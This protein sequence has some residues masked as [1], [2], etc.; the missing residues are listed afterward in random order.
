[1]AI[2]TNSICTT[3]KEI[4][5]QSGTGAIKIGTFASANTITIG[6]TTGA[7]AIVIN[8][9]SGGISMPSFT[10]T[11]ALVSNSSGLITDA[12]ASTSG[13][14]LTSNGAVTAPSFQ[15]ISASGAITTI[16]GN[17]GSVTP[18]TGAVTISGTGPIS[19]S[20]SS[21]T[22]TISTTAANTINATSGTA[23]ASSNAFTIVGAGTVSTSA[24][25]STIT[26]TG[27]GGGGGLSWNNVTGSTQA[28]AVNTGYVNNGSGTPTVFTLPSTAAVG[29][30][31]AVQGANSGLWQIAQN[32]GQTIAF[33]AITST[34]GTGGS[35]TAT[36]RYDTLYLICITANTGWAYNSGFGN[37]TIA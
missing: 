1:M 37:Y 28:M 13:Y 12:N 34:S 23:T 30:I 4:D 3:N 2:I 17:S 27:S 25:G 10:T 19:T 36:G 15:A 18:T 29:D 33:N 26:I 31:V 9:G 7:S 16:N 6:N 8:A 22:L 5:I 14:V 20:G 21:S 32:A 35:V 11:G 24:T